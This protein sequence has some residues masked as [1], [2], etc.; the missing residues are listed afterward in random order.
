M[1]SLQ[2]HLLYHSLSLIPDAHHASGFPIM[3][4]QIGSEAGLMRLSRLLISITNLRQLS[5]EHRRRLSELRKH[6]PSEFVFPFDI[7]SETF[8]LN[9]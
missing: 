3:P 7:Y 8:D 4:V 1:Q 9:C 5:L 2:C 6:L